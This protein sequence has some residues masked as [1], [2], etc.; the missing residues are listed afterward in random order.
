M[1]R[2]KKSSTSCSTARLPNRHQLETLKREFGARRSLP[3]PLVNAMQNV[4][5]TAWP[6]DVLRTIVS[7]LG[8]LLAGQRAA[9][10]ISPTSTPRSS[11]SPK[12][13]RSSPRGIASAAGS[14]RS[15]RAPISRRPANFLYMRSGKQPH[16]IEEDALD[17]YFVLLADHSFNAS[18]FA[19]RVA[20]STR[21]DIYASI[22]AAIATLQGDL[23]GG[24]ATRRLRDVSVEAEIA[25]ERRA[26]RARH[27]DSGTSA[28]WAWGIANTK[29]A[30]RARVISKRWHKKLSE[31]VGGNEPLVRDRARGRRSQPQSAAREKTGQHDLRQRR[32]LHCAG[33]G[34]SRDPGRRVHL[35]LRMRPHRGMDGARARAAGRQSAYSSASDVRRPAGRSVRADRAAIGERPPR[36]EK[37][38]RCSSCRRST[39]AAANACA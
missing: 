20:A 5:K 10:S 19:A 35:S 32:L 7:G 4:P 34:R 27:L 26:V 22:T 31:H 1:R 11:S 6:M 14:T 2:S 37:R 28:S 9:A 3:E 23:H 36:L 39:Y 33:V 16:A 30:I 29:C 21:A 15:S 17:T 13:R 24:A 18:T 12:C 25:R 38:A 8:A